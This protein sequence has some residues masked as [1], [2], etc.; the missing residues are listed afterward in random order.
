MGLGLVGRS[1]LWARSA[2]PTLAL[3]P[4]EVEVKALKEEFKQRGLLTATG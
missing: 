2:T 1:W 3:K 4:N